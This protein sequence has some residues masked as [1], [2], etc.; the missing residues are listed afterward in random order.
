MD[1]Y[2]QYRDIY[3]R[4]EWCAVKFYEMYDRIFLAGT[5][6]LTV[7]DLKQEAQIEVFTRIPK[8]LNEKKLDKDGKEIE[9]N[10]SNNLKNIVI[11]YVMWKLLYL[12]RRERP[13]ITKEV[14]Q[15]DYSVKCKEAD[16]YKKDYI[17]KISTSFEDVTENEEK[18]QSIDLKR[19]TDPKTV[20]NCNF[21][22]QEIEPFLTE[23]EYQVICLIIRDNYTYREVGEMLGV[24]RTW[25]NKYYNDA[26]NKLKKMKLLFR[27]KGGLYGKNESK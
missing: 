11:K 1:N 10:D 16:R 15:G 24:S 27:I 3:E 9:I 26:I 22:F 18:S 20:S 23:K 4:A 6:G 25:I 5:E 7:D 17:Y 21:R 2:E 14:L 13:Y 8:V 19:L 12:L